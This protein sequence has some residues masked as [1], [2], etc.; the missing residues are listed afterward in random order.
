MKEELEAGP[1]LADLGALARI[2]YPDG[3]TAV[4]RLRSFIDQPVA[5][6]IIL[7]LI[8]EI[9]DPVEHT[10]RLLLAPM[11]ADG[12]TM[13]V[14]TETAVDYVDYV[15]DGR[16]ALANQ[17]AAEE[18][19]ARISPTERD[20]LRMG[21]YGPEKLGLPERTTLP[22]IEGGS[23][24]F[25]QRH[26]FMISPLRLAAAARAA[27]NRKPLEVHIMSLLAGK[28]VAVRE[29]RQ[30]A[31]AAVEARFAAAVAASSTRF[32]AGEVEWQVNP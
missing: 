14:T 28:S 8:T 12:G 30:S 32:A 11:T 24:D 23:K 5:L 10:A 17:R 25:Q 9:L 2:Q 22:A 31:E 27:A 15:N 4:I 1:D 18:A 29:A 20:D 7:P 16:E 21:A 13:P 3:R 26:F 19:W 6:S